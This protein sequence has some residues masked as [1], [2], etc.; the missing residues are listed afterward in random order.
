MK[1]T[2]LPASPSDDEAVWTLIRQEARPTSEPKPAFAQDTTRLARNIEQ[3][4]SGW[5]SR[6]QR[7]FVGE[8]VSAS[9]LPWGSLSAA[10][11]VIL[12]LGVTFLASHS[13][14]ESGAVVASTADAIESWESISVTDPLE[15]GM[16]SDTS[17]GE[18][19]AEEWVEMAEVAHLLAQTDVAQFSDEELMAVVFF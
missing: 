19:L 6:I 5:W 18:S 4:P 3:D 12:L 7:L 1:D 16:M 11:A 17:V 10:A 9:A 13:S 14:P 8:S 15:P 2:D